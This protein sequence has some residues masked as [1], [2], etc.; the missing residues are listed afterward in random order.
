MLRLDKDFG[1]FNISTFVYKRKKIMLLPKKTTIIIV[2]IRFEYF[3]LKNC[4]ISLMTARS[5]NDDDS[6]SKK[7]GI[8]WML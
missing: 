1:T 6:S 5:R 4:E 2:P 7:I 3:L 8:E